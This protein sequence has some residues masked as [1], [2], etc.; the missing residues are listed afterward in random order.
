LKSVLITGGAG[1]IGLKL[2]QKLAEDGCRVDL[3]DDF[4]RGRADVEVSALRGRDGVE[5]ITLDL[6]AA[7]ATDELSDGY[8]QIFH[9]A[10]ILGVANVMNRPYETLSR[11]VEMTIE[12][13]RLARRQRALTAFVFASTSEVY[14]GS[15][16]AGTLSFP[17]PE[18]SPLTLPPLDAQRTSY[19]LSKLYGEA[20]TL[21]S[22]VPCVI[23]RPHNVY[24]PRMGTEHV[25]PEL[26]NR[27]RML[28]R[29]DVLPIYSPDHKRTFCYIDDAI[30]MIVRL[31][32][33]ADAL[34]TVWNIGSESPEY[35][36]MEVAQI[37]RR[38]MGSAASLSPGKNTPGSPSRRCPAMA[39][40]NGATGW[41]DRVSLEEGIARSYDW[42]SHNVFPTAPVA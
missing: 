1:F 7:K 30:E 31:A 33:N 41:T 2:A 12:A 20:L 29:G 36:M 42:Y 28:D 22:G 18:D 9:L 15:L 17:T 23:V 5:L 35:T 3:L 32:A 14:A 21:Q 19:M 27:M 26:M 25:I 8:D 13:L 6:C 37:I 4:S 24:G 38:I 34:G 40:T 39:R 11:N 16:L 10:A